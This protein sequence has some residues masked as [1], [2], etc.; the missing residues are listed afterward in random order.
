MSGIALPVL[1]GRG[2]GASHAAEEVRAACGW[3][4]T[5]PAELVQASRRA[6]RE[7]GW[8]GA[9][10]DDAAP[11]AEIVAALAQGGEGAAAALRRAARLGAEC[12]GR[13]MAAEALMTGHF[14][15]AEAVRRVLAEGP[16][17]PSKPVLDALEGAVSLAA[18]AA[19]LGHA[20]PELEAE[21]RW[22]AVLDELLEAA[23]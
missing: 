8:D 15:L 3:L 9:G 13:G 4:G 1:T 19:L 5:H 11:R 21:G 14:L 12:R 16:S 23:G 22:P 10:A 7:A 18:A 2:P 17:A 20:R 6:G